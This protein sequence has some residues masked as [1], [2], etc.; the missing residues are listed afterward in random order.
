MTS[1]RPLR[2]GPGDIPRT[3]GA[4][5]GLGLVVPEPSGTVVDVTRS[6]GAVPVLMD[7]RDTAAVREGLKGRVNRSP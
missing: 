7:H 6:G 3:T 2:M 5:A 1:R 4:A